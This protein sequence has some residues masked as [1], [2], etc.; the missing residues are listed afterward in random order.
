GARG[1]HPGRGARGTVSPGRLARCGTPSGGGRAGRCG[2]RD[3]RST[4]E[5]VGPGPGSADAAAL[6]AAPRHRGTARGTPVS[7]VPAYLFPASVRA[8]GQVIRDGGCKP[9][10]APSAARDVR[11][12]GRPVRG[13]THSAAESRTWTFLRVRRRPGTA[14]ANV[15]AGGAMR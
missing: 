9:C 3:L 14:R 4:P 7:R 5:G 12:H 1:L 6:E 8:R 10:H 15:G 2:T 13:S 11:P